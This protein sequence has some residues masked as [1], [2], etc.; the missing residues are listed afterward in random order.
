M[1]AP[2]LGGTVEWCFQ[3][4]YGSLLGFIFPNFI[5]VPLMVSMSG[6]MAKMLCVASVF[7]ITF[8]AS[9]SMK[10]HLARQCLIA[11]STTVLLHA[12][13]GE[14]MLEIC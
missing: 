14:G 9:Y 10:H 4:I 12:V 8:L 2:T 7:V 1:T 11:I 3:I 13:K 6:A 5:I